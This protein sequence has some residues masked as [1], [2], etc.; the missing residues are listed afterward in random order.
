MLVKS[1]SPDSPNDAKEEAKLSLAVGN[2]NV[3]RHHCLG[4]LACM[5]SDSLRN[6]CSYIN[7]NGTHMAPS[8]AACKNISGCGLD[9]SHLGLSKQVSKRYQLAK[10]IVWPSS[11]LQSGDGATKD[12]DSQ[13]ESK[14]GIESENLERDSYFQHCKDVLKGYR[15]LSIPME[16]TNESIERFSI[17]KYA[18]KAGALL[19]S[20]RSKN[21]FS[22]LSELSSSG[23]KSSSGVHI[24]LKGTVHSTLY[25]IIALACC[26]E[27]CIVHT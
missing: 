14:T 13:T 6:F 19:N 8:V 2:L 22:L 3:L 5:V 26:Y 12:N 24:K 23:S 17:G 1:L 9:D 27:E 15:S 10:S 18:W 7:T 11:E 16:L 25:A 20:L 21:L 4:D